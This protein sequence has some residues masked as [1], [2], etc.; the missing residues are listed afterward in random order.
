MIVNYNAFGC[1]L[2]N[3]LRGQYLWIVYIKRRNHDSLDAF[4]R[5]DHIQRVSVVHRTINAYK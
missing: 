2:Y 1:L 5:L 4:I 3:S